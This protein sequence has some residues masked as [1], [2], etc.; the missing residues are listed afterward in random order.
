[1][2]RLDY[3]WGS[4]GEHWS[5]LATASSA[6][7][8]EFE[9]L[10]TIAGDLLLTLHASAVAP[11]A[12]AEPKAKYRWY[13][14]IWHHMTSKVPD[15]KAFAGPDD[16]IGTVFTGRIREPV[17]LSAT[18][19]LQFSTVR[20]VEPPA[21]RLV[22]FKQ[23]PVGKFLWWFGEEPLRKLLGSLVVAGVL[24]AIP[25]IRHAIASLVGWIISRF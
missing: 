6:A 20:V 7:K 17:E 5:V 1:L 14:A 8:A 15:H 16:R 3:Q 21:T 12:L 25:P 24:A 2:F 19:C 10:C 23:S 22:R 4:A 18:L 9:T 13:L 11:E